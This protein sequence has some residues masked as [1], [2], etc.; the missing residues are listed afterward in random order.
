MHLALAE[1]ILHRYGLPGEGLP[2]DIHRRL[3]QQRGPFLLGNT[4]PDVQTVSKQDRLETHFYTLPRTTDQPA[5]K[6]LFTA[7]PAL[8]H[9]AA[10][11]PAQVAFV[12]GYIAHLLLDEL[13]LDHIFLRYF[14]NQTWGTR[15]ERAFLHNVLRTWMD[16]RDQRQLNGSVGPALHTA[17]PQSWLPFMDDEHLRAWRDWLVHQLEPGQSAQTAEVFAGRMGI[18]AAE[19]QAVLESPAQMEQRVFSRI[20]QATLQA[21]HDAGYEQSVAL[22]AQYLDW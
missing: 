6:V 1:E 11:P 16:A 21:F 13:W 2:P 9:P 17:E 3:I 10:L 4:A 14:R 18:S 12:A 22:I 8:A 5:H 15:H 7:Y 20:P 19:M